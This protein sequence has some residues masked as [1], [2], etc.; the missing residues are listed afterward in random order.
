MKLVVLLG[1]ISKPLSCTDLWKE[2]WLDLANGVQTIN[3]VLKVGPFG[4]SKYTD[5]VSSTPELML[6]MYVLY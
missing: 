5:L 6:E 4:S 3:L 1:K 2:K